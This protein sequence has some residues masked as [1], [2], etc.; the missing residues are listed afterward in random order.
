M[1]DLEAS[2]TESQ[3]L[4]DLDDQIADLLI[5]RQAIEDGVDTSDIDDQI[6]DLE[7]ELDQAKADREAALSVEFND[8]N[9]SL[10]SISDLDDQI[11]IA[12]EELEDLLQQREDLINQEVDLTDIDAEIAA[13]QEVVR[14]INDQKQ[15]EINEA[16]IE[17]SLILEAITE[18]Y[19]LQIESILDILDELNNT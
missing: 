15:N 13:Q 19:T 12:K 8:H 6:A 16:I 1:A 11:A 14:L 10:D 17:H 5:Q 2:R 4:N 18:K 3:E 7:V 9:T